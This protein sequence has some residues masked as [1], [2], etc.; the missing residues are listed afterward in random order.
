MVELRV[1]ERLSMRINV[2]DRGWETSNYEPDTYQIKF[3]DKI[4]LLVFD[5]AAVEVFFNGKITWQLRRQGKV[6]RL[7]FVAQPPP[8]HDKPQSM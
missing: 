1:K 5:A 2:D 3:K 4:N 6:R 8:S 7:S